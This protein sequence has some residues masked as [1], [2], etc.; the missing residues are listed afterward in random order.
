MAAPAQDVNDPA[1]VERL[2]P[3]VIHV[4][5]AP[6]TFEAKGKE[7]SQIT[8]TAFKAS[9]ISASGTMSAL[10]VSKPMRRRNSTAMGVESHA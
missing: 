1:L 3:S 7:I 5:G 8:K 9:S 4:L 6:P 10:G 2:R